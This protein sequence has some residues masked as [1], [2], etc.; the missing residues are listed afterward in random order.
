MPVG[1][2]LSRLTSAELTEW[3]AYFRLENE[4]EPPKLRASTAL[5]AM[6]AHRVKKKDPCP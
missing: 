6:F 4:P 2:L 5:K 1:E 3:M